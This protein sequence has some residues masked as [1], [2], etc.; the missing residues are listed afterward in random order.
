MGYYV[1]V[2][3]IEDLNKK[4]LL[5]YFLRIKIFLFNN[6]NIEEHFPLQLSLKESEETINNKKEISNISLAEMQEE[7]S[8][9]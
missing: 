3:V 4:V 1:P 7:G 8:I 9:L 5:Y 6:M 2:T